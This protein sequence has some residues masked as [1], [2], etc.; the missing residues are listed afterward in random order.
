MFIQE[1]Y[2][3]DT[4]K[5]SVSHML[6]AEISLKR[7]QEYLQK[8]KIYKRSLIYF[9]SSCCCAPKKSVRIHKSC[10]LVRM[11]PMNEW[12][13]IAILLYQYYVLVLINNAALCYNWKSQYDA[14]NMVNFCVRKKKNMKS[15]TW[16]S[17]HSKLHSRVH[18][19]HVPFVYIFINLG[20]Y[21]NLDI[22]FRFHR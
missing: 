8:Q 21:L 3:S 12:L 5:K 11:V 15:S 7:T 13:I 19:A 17:W 16:D 6:M 10:E 9:V 18:S 14:S 2:S 4:W 22:I 20:G 1:I